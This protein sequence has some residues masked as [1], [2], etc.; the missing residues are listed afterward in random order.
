MG[1][2][3]ELS[4]LFNRSWFWF[5]VFETLRQM[6]LKVQT[7]LIYILKYSML[8]FFYYFIHDKD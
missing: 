1:I 8:F 5:L 6:V 2:T 4:Q 3:T 7:L